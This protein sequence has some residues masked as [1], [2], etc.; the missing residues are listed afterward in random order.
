MSAVGTQ[1]AE[2]VSSIASFQTELDTLKEQQSVAIRELGLKHKEELAEL[3][4]KS[5]KAKK[6]FAAYLKEAGIDTFL[7]P[8][9]SKAKAKVGNKDKTPKTRTSSKDK[10]AAIER[11]RSIYTSSYEKGIND[12]TG[13]PNKHKGRG[14]KNHEID[15]LMKLDEAAFAKANK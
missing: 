2:L 10:K 3:N 4:A 14:N 13:L 11:N 6:E 12:K 15:K 7:A 8:A 1:I 9:K 5:E